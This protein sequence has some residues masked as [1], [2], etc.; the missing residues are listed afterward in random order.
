MSCGLLYITYITVIV[1]YYSVVSVY[2]HVYYYNTI[3]WMASYMNNYYTYENNVTNFNNNIL[4]HLCF[5]ESTGSKPR[6]RCWPGY[7][8]MWYIL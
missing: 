1:K 3:I 5:V 2:S 8:L 7:K 6:F 4:L